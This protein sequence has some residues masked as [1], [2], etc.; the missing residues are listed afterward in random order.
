MAP[1]APPGGAMG[2]TVGPEI[3]GRYAAEAGFSGDDL[4]IAIAVALAESGGRSDSVS[5]V[6]PKDGS[7]DYGHWQINDKAHAALFTQYPRWGYGPDNARMAYAVW[8]G[9]GWKAWTTYNSGAY[10]AHME[11]A[12]RG[13]ANP[14]LPTQQGETET[15][16]AP[17]LQAITNGVLQIAQS[18]FKAGAWMADPHNWVRASLVGLG[19]A[20]VVGALVIVAKPVVAPIV[21]P[22]VKKVQKV[23]A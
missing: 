21:A 19:G 22:A 23:V 7:R 8:Q 15:V 18:V 11:A 17:W 6:N 1:M 2:V 13:A 9:S 16:M 20:L 4:T 10:R 12:A 3:L 5:P 14:S